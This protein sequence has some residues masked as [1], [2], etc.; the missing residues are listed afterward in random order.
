MPSVDAVDV[1]RWVS[2]G[3][4]ENLGFLQSIGKRQAIFAHAGEDVI[5]GTI[6]D[7]DDELEAVSDEA[8][9]DGLDDGDSAGDAGFEK[10]L[11]TM[12][13]D[14]GKDFR[15]MLAEQGLVSGDDNLAGTE[16]P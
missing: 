16:C 15:T 13:A 6:E 2:F 11:A 12:L 10:E 7:A 5:T 8:F 3:V 9:A 4:T 14:G 1:E